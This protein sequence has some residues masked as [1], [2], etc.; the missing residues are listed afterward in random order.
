MFDKI[1]IANRGEIAC[2]IIKTARQMGIRTVA[3]FSDAD[4]Q[5]RHVRLAD[6]AVYIGAAPARESYLDG[7]K[8]I[9]AAKATGA[10]AIH[11]G[12]G[13]L[14][15]NE[16][17]SLAC[18]QAE[19]VFIGPPVEAIRVMGLKSQAKKLMGAAGI[20]LI[21]GYHGEDQ[22]P[23][24]LQKEA[25]AIGY[26]VLIKA[27]AGGGG[28]GMRLV[29]RFEDF[30]PN[31][32]A[33]QREAQAAFGDDHVLIERY[34]TRPRHVEIQI[35]GDS[36]GN[37]V[38]LFERDCSVQRRHQKVVEE[39]PAP[40]FSEQ[41]RRIMGKAATDAA[42]AVHYAGAG[43]VEFI[44]APDGQFYFME[45]NTRL[46]VEH[47][48]TEMI[49]GLDLVEWQLRVAS[50]EQ[51][52]VTQ[53]DLSHS[54]HAI[55]ARIY[56][57]DPSTGFL[58]STGKLV[59]FQLPEESAHVRIDA[60]VEEGDV[61]SRFYD[62]MIAKLIVWDETR[63][64]ALR[65]ME[66]ALADMQIAG[67]ASNIEFLS[68]LVT[69]RSFVQADLDTGLIER[70]A[71]ALF[72][73]QELPAE[74]FLLATLAQ[75]LHEASGA[76]LNSF[77]QRRDGFRLNTRVRRDLTF[78]S[79]TITHIVSVT[80]QDA[81]YRLQAGSLDV[82]VTGWQDKGSRIIAEIDGLRKTYTAVR[83]DNFIYLFT[84]GQ[85]WK[86]EWLDPLDVSPDHGTGHDGLVAPMP[87]S[88]TALLVAEGQQVAKGAPLLI[89]EAMK[90][91]FKI[92]APAA[93][94]VKAFRCA[95]GDQVNEGAE[96]ADFEGV[97]EIVKTET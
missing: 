40:H 33:C 54:G 48:V 19:I 63:D 56:A 88:I 1:L 22:A 66:R 35:F 38:S 43:T 32:F 51:L 73:P 78:R 20:P 15:E 81:G 86:F 64:K 46:Q 30:T 8:I 41:Q 91:E 3:V 97:D 59:H 84:D 82:A 16:A 75:L 11:P 28:K 39:A 31:L 87:G 77:L 74:M 44:V 68:R 37:Y 27:S 62:P 80:Y 53:E 10:Q 9:A 7:A 2:R 61:I 4:A 45:M 42:R 71:A 69:C 26:P 95:V 18:M 17:F 85:S 23:E 29:E 49:T 57:E 72:E 90:M 5:A 96:L 79:G 14:S 24:N 94:Y 25:D 83:L 55:E 21:P 50:G 34:I 93:G 67:V 6:E 65:R 36:H 60:G 92:T 76:A 70:E 52:P 58:P 12:Y 89:V 47:P 13:F